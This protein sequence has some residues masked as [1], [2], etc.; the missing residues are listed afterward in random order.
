MPVGSH[1][2]TLTADGAASSVAWQGG[3]G[4][5]IAYGTFGSGT[6]ALQFSPDNGNTWI[7]AG[8]SLTADG[9]GAFD[10][11]AGVSLRANLSGASS[12]SVNVSIRENPPRVA[13]A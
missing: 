10:L 7:D 5:L 2:E 13:S 3:E 8:V 12:P 9:H 1:A 4:T 11:P 6:V